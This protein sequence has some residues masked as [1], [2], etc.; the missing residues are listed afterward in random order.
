[1]AVTY[2]TTFLQVL[3]M[4]EGSVYPS[5]NETITRLFHFPQPLVTTR[6]RLDQMI[7]A[8]TIALKIEL[9][10][11]DTATKHRQQQPFSGGTVFT[12]EL[13]QLDILPAVTN[14]YR[15]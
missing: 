14:C 13:S 3:A 5:S 6:V 15:T 7:G 11:M 10:G 8:P 4:Y 2:S 12:S 1:M 9:L